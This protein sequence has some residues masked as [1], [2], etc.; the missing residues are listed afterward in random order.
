MRKELTP[1]LLQLPK[2]IA[3]LPTPPDVLAYAE[4]CKKKE[5]LRKQEFEDLVDQ[6]KLQ[7]YYGG[8]HVR[9]LLTKQGRV[10]VV[11]D[12]D[13]DVEGYRRKVQA[14][15]PDVRQDSVVGVPS[16]WMDETSWLSCLM[17]L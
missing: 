5:W 1:E 9:Y 15:P 4:E 14:L 13:G 2:R 12:E 10:V 6:L 3:D 16:P 8:W 17:D 7:Y 11:I